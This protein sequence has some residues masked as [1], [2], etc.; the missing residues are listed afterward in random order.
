MSTFYKLRLKVKLKALN[1][2]ITN[3][4]KHRNKKKRGASDVDKNER[5]SKRQ[6]IHTT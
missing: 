2:A 5:S 1:E 6:K 4:N 3:E